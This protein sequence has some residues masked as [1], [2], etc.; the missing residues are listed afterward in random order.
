MGSIEDRFTAAA[1]GHVAEILWDYLGWPEVPEAG[2]YSEFTHA[3][4]SVLF[5][6]ATRDLNERIDGHTVLVHVRYGGGGA[7]EVR[8]A[9]WLAEQVGQTIIG[10]PLLG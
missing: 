7:Y 9:S 4:V 1:A 5:N 2:L 3:E 8:H 10:P 6:A